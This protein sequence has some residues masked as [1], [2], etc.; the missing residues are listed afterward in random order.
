MDDIRELGNPKQ[1][2]RYDHDPHFCMGVIDAELKDCEIA[3]GGDPH[4]APMPMD[5]FV[6]VIKGP[7]GAIAVDTGFTAE[8]S[9]KRDRKSVV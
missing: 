3:I 5:Y 7:D 9:A 1:T 2:I 4:D 6:W 8:V